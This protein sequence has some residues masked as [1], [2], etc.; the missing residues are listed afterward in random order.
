MSQGKELKKLIQDEEIITA[1]GVFDALSA[2]LAEKA[3]F[4]ALIMGGYSISAAQFGKPDLG[5]LTM[6]EMVEMIR[7]I[8][9]VT[10]IPLI[11]DGDTGFGGEWNVRRSVKEYEKAGAAAI[12]L[13]DQTFPKRC[14][15]LNGKTVIPKNEHAEKIR[16]AKQ[17]A[18]EILVFART[19]ALG[20]SGFDEAISRALL[21]LRSGADGIFIEAPKSENDLIMIGRQLKGH[22]LIVNNIEGG[23]TPVF[24]AEQLKKFGYKIVMYPLTGLYIYAKNVFQGFQTLN[25]ETTSKSLESEMYD[26]DTF[27]EILNIKD[28]IKR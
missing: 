22:T 5:I 15:H 17:T 23:K 10:S 27:N 20:V 11:A 21:Y 25:K 7:R 2:I 6:T 13:E 26:F 8:T 14:G 9:D 3:G 1:P 24:N 28:Y 19:D 16:I 4:K 12:I 18:K